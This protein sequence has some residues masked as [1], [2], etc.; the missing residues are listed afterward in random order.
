MV[1]TDARDGDGLDRG[2]GAR[3]VPA[4]AHTDLEDGH[5]DAR[6]RVY[7]AGGNRQ[8]VEFGHVVGTLA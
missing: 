5:V 7:D 1:E 6:L 3:R 2:D 8:G 4:T